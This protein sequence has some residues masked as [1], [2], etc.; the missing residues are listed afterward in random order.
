MSV[1]GEIVERITGHRNQPESIPFA[2]FDFNN[3]ERGFR[4]LLLASQPINKT[5]VWW[6]GRAFGDVC[7]K[8]VIPTRSW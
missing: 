3:S 7:G 4:T 8:D 6:R 5:S 1:D 2:L